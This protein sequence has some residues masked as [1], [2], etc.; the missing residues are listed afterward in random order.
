MSRIRFLHAADVHLDSP[1][2]SLRSL[3][4][5]TAGQLHRASRRALETIVQTAIDR[6]VAAVVIAGDLFDGPVKDAGA[7]LWVESQFKRLIR[8]KIAVV[9]IRGNHDAISN[10]HRVLR[11]PTGIY[12]LASDRVETVV[13][14]E[15]RLAIHGQSFEARAESKDLAATYPDAL[16][17]YFNIGLLHTSLSGSSQHDCYAPTSLPVLESKGYQYW[18]LGHIHQRTEQSLSQKCWI[19]YSGNTQGR[20]VRETGGKGCYLV[21]LQ[22][23]QIDKME[24]IATDTLRWHIVPVRVSEIERLSDIEDCV[25]DA[26]SPLIKQSLTQAGGTPLA[27]RLQLEGHTSQHAELTRPEV[28]QR[29]SEALAAQI[30]QL[31]SVWLE[32]VKVRTRPAKTIGSADMDLPLKY[33]T[34][35]TDEMR[36]DEALRKEMFDELDE[37]LK[38]ARVELAEMNWPLVVDSTRETELINYLGQAEDLLISRLIKAGEA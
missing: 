18:A 8:E 16:P 6:Q 4:E 9:I 11:W 13:L 19:G 26:L 25:R 10:A 15:A 35:I 1:L 24:F 29:L 14:N 20:H 23:N 37:L 30:Q 3:D 31:G 27:I 22:D 38:K 5:Q 2:C 36:E 17:G 28:L 32:S 33:L 21:E 34:Q 12:E 7:G